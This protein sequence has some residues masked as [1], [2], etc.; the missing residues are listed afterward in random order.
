VLGENDS[1]F[2]LGGRVRRALKEGSGEVV[3]GCDDL[4][5]FLSPRQY[6]E[7]ILDLVNSGH[8]LPQVLNLGSGVGMT[9]SEASKKLCSQLGGNPEAL[10]FKSGYSSVPSVVSDNAKLKS[11]ISF[12]IKPFGADFP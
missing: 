2:T 11:L 6:S 3:T 1:H 10:R 12:D 8:Q 4:R 5:D 9:V 7:I